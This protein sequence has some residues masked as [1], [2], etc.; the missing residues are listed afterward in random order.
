MPAA[1][2]AGSSTASRGWWKVGPAAARD[3]CQFCFQTCSSWS[4]ERFRFIGVVDGGKAAQFNRRYKPPNPWRLRLQFMR[5]DHNCPAIS[6]KRFNWLENGGCEYSIFEPLNALKNR[7]F[8]EKRQAEDLQNFAEA[9]FDAEFP[10][11]NGHE[12]V[13]ADRNPYLNSYCV[14]ARSVERFDMQILFDPF[15]KQLDLP[16]TLV[17]FCDRQCRQC[18]VVGQKH[19]PPFV[20]GVIEHYATQGAWVQP[21]R[22]RAHQHDRLVAPQPR[23]LVNAPTSSASVVEAALGSRYEKRRTRCESMKS[24]EIDI[25]SI[26]YVKCLRARSADGREPSHRGFFRG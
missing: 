22:L 8:L 3:S 20:L 1:W 16:S 13:N 10:P 6:P 25:S 7:G 4:S 18:E 23:R 11:D 19:E 21:R 12:H 15:E 2:V 9:T 14:V 24:F 26:H 17:K 5:L